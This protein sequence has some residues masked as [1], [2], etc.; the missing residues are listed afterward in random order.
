MELTKKSIIITITPT[1]AIIHPTGILLTAIILIAGAG[2]AMVAAE[3]AVVVVAAIDD[4][5]KLNLA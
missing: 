1:K 2:T 5:F 4:R 3:M